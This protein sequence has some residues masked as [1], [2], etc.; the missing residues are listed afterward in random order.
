MGEYADYC[1]DEEM[2]AWGADGEDY[3][4]SNNCPQCGREDCICDS[5][6]EW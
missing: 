3:H 6:E 2:D 4:N 5:P 1:M